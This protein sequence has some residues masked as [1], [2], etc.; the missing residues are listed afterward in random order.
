M[1]NKKTKLGPAN[2]KDVPEDEI[3]L[4][5]LI[6]NASSRGMHSIQ[7][8]SYNGSASRNADGTYEPYFGVNGCCAL[9]AFCLE[10]D[11]RA[12][13]DS[14]GYPNLTVGNDYLDGEGRG[15]NFP[16]IGAAFEQALRPRRG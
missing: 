10:P 5:M 6:Q 2:D 13:L 11:T 9:G 14:F 7:G 16:T 3:H 8:R 1:A 12:A 15:F 4:A